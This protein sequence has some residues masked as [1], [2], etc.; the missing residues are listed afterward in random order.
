[1][2]TGDSHLGAIKRAMNRFGDQ[3]FSR[4]YEVIVD[5]LSS[6]RSI[7]HEISGFSL[8]EDDICLADPRYEN[9]F[10]RSHGG[11]FDYI[12]F[13][14]PFWCYALFRRQ[15]FKNFTTYDMTVR[16]QLMSKNVLDY[17]LENHAAPYLNLI[18][19]MMKN[20]SKVVVIETP[21]LF[22]DHPIQRFTDKEILNYIDARYRSYVKDKLIMLGA[23]VMHIPAET[24]AEYGVM[25][26][27]YLT[28]SPDDFGHCNTEY[29]RLIL[30]QIKSVT[31]SSRY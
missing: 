2:L 19:V 14:A 30:E 29:G 28:E 6:K 5:I 4:E 8:K 11:Q 21:F 26:D 9:G 31:E 7:H 24:V 23:E 25:S 17:I 27:K 22:K 13:N 1:M 15:N 20:A 18:P 12:F 10:F 16:K 3:I